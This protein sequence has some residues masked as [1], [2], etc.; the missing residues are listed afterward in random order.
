MVSIISVENLTKKYKLYDK[1][2]DRLKEALNPFPKK[3]HK[4]FYALKNVSF[5]IK[6]GESI[7]ILGKNGSGKS[8][9]LK[10][11]TGVLNLSEGKVQ[12]NGRVSAI[13]ELG[14]GFNP[15]LTGLENIYLNGTLLGYS[16][17]QMDQKIEEIIDFADIGDFIY[18][19]VKM[20]SSGMFAR[21]A[22][23]VAINVEPD[24]MIVDEALAVGDIAF[25]H[26]CIRK[27]TKMM[28]SGVTV[29]FV[30]HDIGAIKS[31]CQKCMYLKDGVLEAYGDAS[32]VCDIYLKEMRTNVYIT[33]SPDK[34]GKEE[35]TKTSNYL[36]SDI[37][38]TGIFKK[39]R[40]FDRR[41][42]EFRYGT[43][44]AKIECMELLN[45]KKEVCDKFEFNELV[46][47]RAYIEIYDDVKNL[48]CCF[49]IRNQNGI[50][51]MGTTTFEEGHNF[52]PLTPGDQLIV[53][54][55]FNNIL[56]GG[57]SYSVQYTI[58]DTYSYHEQTV[59]DL[60]DNAIVFESIS[61]ADRPIWYELWYPFE[62]DYKKVDRS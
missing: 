4:D 32:E 10:I 12:V 47:L 5:E 60:I 59:L 51:I 22:F 46:T 53:D 15:E 40:N 45:E 36:D 35:T 43:L 7:G 38:A 41:V 1:P 24:I 27:L 48:N 55:K 52:P 44:G 37:L 23:S 25:Q 61:K 42:K 49:I 58:N 16:Q 50:D 21:L 56:K 9:L 3:Y 19:P 14:A 34:Y 30:S 6:P 57:R 62:I 31:V 20:Y 11:L 26:K 33:E 39:D 17:K 8:T 2:S 13:L 29:L 28:K 18:Q 54:F